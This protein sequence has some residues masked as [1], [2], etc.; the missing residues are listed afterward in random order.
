MPPS[1]NRR[2]GRLPQSP[3]WPPPTGLAGG[4]QVGQPGA[5]LFTQ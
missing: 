5:N 3:A 4:M 1:H 2:H